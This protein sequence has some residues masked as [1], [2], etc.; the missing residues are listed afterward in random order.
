VQTGWPCNAAAA[1]TSGGCGTCPL[2]RNITIGF[3]S[4]GACLKLGDSGGPTYTVRFDN[5]I[6]A[7][8][9]M[10]SATNVGGTGNCQVEFTNVRYVPNAWPGSS[11]YTY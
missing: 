2:A 4:S 3:K 11:L 8:G 6:A 9:A 7:K 5:G 10:G 1:V